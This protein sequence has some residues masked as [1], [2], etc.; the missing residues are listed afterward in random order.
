MINKC[1]VEEWPVL[2]N[3]ERKYHLSIEIE[4]DVSMNGF[5]LN[6]GYYNMNL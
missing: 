5:V 6:Y 4:H 2:N 3:H 1:T